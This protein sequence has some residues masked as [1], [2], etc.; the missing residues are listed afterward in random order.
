MVDVPIEMC[1]YPSPSFLFRFSTSG[2]YAKEI[3]RGEGGGGTHAMRAEKSSV[4]WSLRF[5][6]FPSVVEK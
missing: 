2:P 1:A 4:P 5:H 3:G 6:N